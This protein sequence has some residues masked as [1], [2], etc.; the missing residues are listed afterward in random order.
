MNLPIGVVAAPDLPASD[1]VRFAHEV[2]LRVFLCSRTGK[3]LRLDRYRSAALE[4][5]RECRGQSAGVTEL[6]RSRT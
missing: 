2:E 1:V 6:S 3:R 5:P 4:P